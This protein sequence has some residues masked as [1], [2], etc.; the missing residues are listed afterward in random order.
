MPKFID[1]TGQKF[2]NLTAVTREEGASPIKWICK[3][4]CGNIT[5]TRQSRLKAGTCVSCGCKKKHNAATHGMSGTVE[6]RTWRDII[7]RCENVSHKDF[8]DYGGRGIKICKEWRKDFLAFYSDMG[9][10]PS[11]KHSIDRIDNNKGYSK[12]NCKWSTWT[13]Q[14]NNRRNNRKISIN[15]ESKTIAQWA[16]YFRCSRDHIIST[17]T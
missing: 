15:G 12:D 3:C 14:A 13:Q 9:D 8:N 2:G 10:R 5:S 16:R 11:N 4:D 1:I 17:Y 7:N 6:Y